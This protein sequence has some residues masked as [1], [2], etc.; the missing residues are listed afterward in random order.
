MGALSV[1][2]LTL[3]DWAKR[4]DPKGGIDTIVELLAEA[5]PL[6]QDASVIEGNLPTGHRHTERTTVAAGTW[7]KLNQGVAETR[8]TTEQKDDQCGML[9][10]FSAIDADLVS[11][12]SNAAAFRLSEDAGFVSG[13][14]N[15]AEDA[16][17][18]ANALTDP[19][20]MH[21]LEPRYS[22]LTGTP[23]STN[24]ISAAG[25][26]TDNTSVWL[27]TWGPKLTTLIFPQGS[28]AGLKSEDLGLRPW[29][30][31]SYNPYMAWV[32][33]YQWKLGLAVHDY[34][35][36]TRICNIDVSNLTADA[37]TGADL[38]D[39]M[40]KAFYSRPTL[41][42]GNLAQTFFYCNKTVAEYLHKQAMNKGNVQLTVDMPGGKPMVNFLGVP[43]H[44]CDSIGVEEATID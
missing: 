16:I 43:I 26:S 39:K 1:K 15:D 21:G 28:Q 17:L 30:D 29:D 7:R 42:L 23:G 37:A 10:A 44:I 12:A 33:H 32:T 11:L 18:S 5:N 31:A 35:F 14:S 3:A 40:I 13:L 4:L 8:T 27:I 38:L 19:E 34:R 2:F 25:A 6:V 24:V 20:K 22:S 9:E 36:V 41:A